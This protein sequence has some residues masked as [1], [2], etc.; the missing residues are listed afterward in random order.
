MR[1]N[2]FIHCLVAIAATI[3]LLVL[4]GVNAATLIYVAAVLVCPLMMVFMMRGMM[5]DS[6]QVTHR[7]AASPAPSAAPRR[8]RVTARRHWARRVPVRLAGAVHSRWHRGQRRRRGRRCPAAQRREPTH[9]GQHGTQLR[10]ARRAS[11]RNASRGEAGT[12]TS[13][14]ASAKPMR[15]SSSPAGVSTRRSRPDASTDITRAAVA[16]G[17]PPKARATARTSWKWCSLSRC[18]ASCGALGIGLSAPVVRPRP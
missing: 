17:W 7:R 3:A 1:S 2:H 15:V 6:T 4:F 16:W 14:R 10:R 5:G 9:G 11:A 12:S 8:P 18:T 13:G